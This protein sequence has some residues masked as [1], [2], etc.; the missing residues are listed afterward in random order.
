MNRKSNEEVLEAI[1][2][3]SK[4]INNEVLSQTECWKNS[5][6]TIT[7]IYRY[8]PKW[9]DACRAAGV[10]YDPSR[11]WVPDEE[12]LSDWGTVTREL[13]HIPSL[14]EYKVYGKYSR[15]AFNRFGN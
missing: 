7:D 2:Q 5:D 6:I 4:S 11:D 1:R 12:V 3:A 10:K 15:Q 9:S 13:G 8:F 14:T